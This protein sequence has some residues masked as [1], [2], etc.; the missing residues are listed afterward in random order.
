MRERKVSNRSRG[1]R[2]SYA[3]N[4]REK[5]GWKLSNGALYASGH[6]GDDVRPWERPSKSPC[7]QHDTPDGG[8]TGQRTPCGD[9]SAK[10]AITGAGDGRQRWRWFVLWFKTWWMYWPLLCAGFENSSQTWGGHSS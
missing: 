8:W 5:R 10:G 6:S 4:G 9:T 3:E 2:R 1:V 7:Q